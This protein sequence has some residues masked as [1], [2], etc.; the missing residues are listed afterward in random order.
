MLVDAPR[1]ASGGVGFRDV[2]FRNQGWDNHD[3]PKIS[4]VV[5]GI[6]LL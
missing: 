6:M 5:K 4:M 1:G 3:L 2:G